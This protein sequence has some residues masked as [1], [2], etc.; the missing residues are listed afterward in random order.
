MS[1]NHQPVGWKNCQLRILCADGTT[2]T[3]DCNL[4]PD[5]ACIMGPPSNLDYVMTLGVPGYPD[6]V[7]ISSADAIETTSPVILVR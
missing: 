7:Q 6:T 4:R 5:I 2:I 3:N 1:L